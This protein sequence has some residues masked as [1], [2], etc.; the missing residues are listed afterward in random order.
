MSEHSKVALI[1]RAYEAF[2][3]GDAETVR[4]LL[5]DDLVWHVPGRHRFSGDHDKAAIMATMG[6]L[7]P[8]F[9]PTGEAV[10]STFKIELEDVV[11]TDEWAFARVH[12]MHTRDGRRF[13]QRGVEVYRLNAQG[14]IAE[15]WALMRDTAAFD[16]FFA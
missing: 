7:V 8:E 14:R 9:S 1:R 6:E 3:N 16:E 10:I 5:A 4:D 11:A 13:D 12:W 2:K 15:F